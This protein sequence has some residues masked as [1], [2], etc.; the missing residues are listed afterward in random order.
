M[1]PNSKLEQQ[2]K[3]KLAERTIQPRPMAWDRLDAM[4]TVAEEK[5]AA[6][7]ELKKKPRRDWL[8][9]AAV[10]SGFLMM[11][12]I[13]L[14]AEKENKG[15]III[16]EEDTFVATPQHTDSTHSSTLNSVSGSHENKTTGIAVTANEKSPA[17]V[18]PYSN[19]QKVTVKATQPVAGTNTANNSKT[20]STSQA[21]ANNASAGTK[22]SAPVSNT[23][24]AAAATPEQTS[25]ISV[26]ASKL[27]A[28][29][30]GDSNSGISNAGA[31]KTSVKVDSKS[32]LSS[33]EGELNESFRSKV[34]NSAIKN[35]N[36][37]KTSVAN[38]NYQ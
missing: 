10:C 28:S 1:E 26:S 27:L 34:L 23:A 36:A 14:N 17:T 25:G 19:T 9:A 35:Y 31:A 15:N 21:F 38:R 5:Q 37:V 16:N 8:W 18:N 29:V 4:L 6:P 2:I 20:G 11:G 13:M 30:E 24:T 32:L 33:V 22:P 3:E 12:A 7:A